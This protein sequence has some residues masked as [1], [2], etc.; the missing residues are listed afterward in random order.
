[1]E[2]VKNISLED[3]TSYFANY[4]SSDGGRVVV[5]GDVKQE[6]LL[7]QL[8]FLNQ[9]PN[10]KVTLPATVAT[11]APIEKTK[12]YIVD[13]PNAAQTEFRIGKVTDLKYDPT[14]E[15]Y[16]AVLTNYNLGGAFNSRL[17][18]NLREDKGWT[19]GARSN[20][21][22]D[23]YTGTFTF[24]SGIRAD[25]TD[26]A[27]TEIVSEI[28]NYTD[29]GIREEEIAFMRNS[30]GQSEA[31]NYETGPQKA[32]FL[33][34]ILEYNLAADYVKKQNELVRTISKSDI[35]GLARKYIDLNKMNIVL[36]GDKGKILPGLQRFGYDIVE[37]NTEGMPVK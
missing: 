7:P 19:Y 32:A 18:I 25:A 21:S 10:K 37:L 11:A 2:S 8:A 22:G 4:F 17:N 9:L 34:R 1:M 29:K 14:G 24:S 3:I 15:Y 26:S 35:D 28:K 36:V 23:K 6:E 31:R 33:G 27:L 5:V 16:K 30:I 13:V 12:I 20:F